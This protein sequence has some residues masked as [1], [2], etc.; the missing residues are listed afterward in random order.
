MGQFCWMSSGSWTPRVLFH[1]DNRWCERSSVRC[2]P[3]KQKAVASSKE[4]GGGGHHYI[5]QKGGWL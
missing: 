5:V 1:V 3:R 2:K 4:V